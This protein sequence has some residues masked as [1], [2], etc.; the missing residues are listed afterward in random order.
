MIMHT[1]ELQKPTVFVA[2]TEFDRLANLAAGSHAAGAELLAEELDRA[3]V[4]DESETP[5]PFVRLNSWVEYVDLLS[6]RTRTVQVS[7]PEAADMDENRVS[8][9]TPVGAALIGLTAGASFGWTMKDGRPR[10]LT[11]VRVAHPEETAEPKKAA[12]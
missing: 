8:V 9:V 5:Q 7:L 11:I 2:E 6:G 4:V 3:V 1:S 12:I 10:V